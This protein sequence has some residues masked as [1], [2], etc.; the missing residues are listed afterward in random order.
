MDDISVIIVGAAFGGLSS[1][2]ELASRG[3][4]VHVFEASKDL[5]RQGMQ[6]CSKHSFHLQQR[7]Q[8]GR[9]GM[10]HEKPR[11]MSN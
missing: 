1:A 5:S 11:L 2:I 8:G 3:C 6:F 4:K 7:S 9:E 10:A